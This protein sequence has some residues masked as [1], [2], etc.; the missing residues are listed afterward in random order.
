MFAQGDGIELGRQVGTLVDMDQVQLHPTAFVPPSSPSSPPLKESPKSRVLAPEALRGHGG[1]LVNAQGH[2]F[3]NELGT[4]QDVVKAILK[5]P[6][7]VYLV[8][9]DEG[10][11]AFGTVPFQFYLN[12]RFFQQVWVH[13][14]HDLEKTLLKYQHMAHPSSSSSSSSLWPPTSSGS[15]SPS[16]S[17]GLR[18]DV[19]GKSVF[20]NV[21]RELPRPMKVYV[22]QV[23]PALHYCMGGL[24]INQC[25]QVIQRS[26]PLPTTTKTSTISSSVMDTHALERGVP[27]LFAAGEVTGGILLDVVSLEC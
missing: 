5:Q 12:Q 11:Q 16:T 2:R 22:A 4:R 24:K 8:L 10:V 27:G 20:P 17:L 23:A 21:P 13:E 3:V 7:P 25:A 19:F 14:F 15:F 26:S 18:T 6:G 9:F 1:I